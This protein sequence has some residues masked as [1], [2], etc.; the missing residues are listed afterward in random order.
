[1]KK[2]IEETLNK[3]I[4]GLN[5]PIE[6]PLTKTDSGYEGTFKIEDK[7]Y[8]TYFNETSENCYVFNFT[9]DGEHTLKHDIKKTFTVIPTITKLVTDFMQEHTPNLFVFT[10][11]DGSRGRDKYYSHFSEKIS[12]KYGYNYLKKTVDDISVF[13]LHK[14]KT[15]K[16]DYNNMIIYL[17]NNKIELN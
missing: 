4:E 11:T 8:D 16:E 10:K 2:L 3:I 7:V 1:M 13:I 15:T 17:K 6:V 5:E 12:K 14:E 9:R